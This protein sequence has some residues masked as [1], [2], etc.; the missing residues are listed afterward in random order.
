MSVWQKQRI[1]VRYQGHRLETIEVVS[2]HLKT[3]LPIVCDMKSR[4]IRYFQ[5]LLFFSTKENQDY[6]PLLFSE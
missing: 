6:P 4:Q 5:F 2:N 1:G 3:L